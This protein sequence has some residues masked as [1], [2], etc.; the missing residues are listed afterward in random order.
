M[1]AYFG[2]LIA[3]TM[4]AL[5]LAIPGVALLAALFTFGLAAVFLIPL[6]FILVALWSI[7][8]A[9]LFWRIPIVR[10]PLLIAGIIGTA[11]LYL[12][13]PHLAELELSADLAVQNN[14]LPNSLGS[15][16]L[17][18]VEIRRSVSANA[19][20]RAAGKAS[21]AFYSA[22]PCFELCERLL[23]GGDVAWVR[24]VL[25]NDAY[26][27]D[28][29]RTHAIL[30]PGN[31]MQCA[32][33]NADFPPGESCALYAPDH[34]ELAD[35]TIT[36]EDRQISWGGDNFTPYQPIGYRVATGHN[37]SDDKSPILFHQ[38]QI[39]YERPTGMV[40]YDFGSLGRGDSGEGGF[41]FVRSRQASKPVDLISIANLMGLALGPTIELQPKTPGTEDNRFI[42]PPPDAQD[43]AYV[44]SLINAGPSHNPTQFSN[45]FAQVINDWHRRLRWKSSLSEA[46]RT[47]FCRTL[48]DRRIANLFWEDQ[49]IRKH[50]GAC[51]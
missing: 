8:P 41:E 24:I 45:A 40:S 18:G 50:G 31:P 9:V 32:S 6:P 17:V 11:S 19:N 39:F 25:T 46:D 43:A 35:L 4:I 21:S 42:A 12:L 48:F 34:G 22:K 27:N 1:K 29:A 5:V 44:A 10:W 16:G 47:I 51:R 7:L 23:T 3:I 37:G 20:F 15:N 36:L 2:I 49:V 38:T 28:R 26:A 33:I 13:P 30:A 14:F